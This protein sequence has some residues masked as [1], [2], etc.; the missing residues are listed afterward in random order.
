MDNLANRPCPGPSVAAFRAWVQ[1]ALA[2]LNLSAAGLG[3]DIGL[4][5][6]T[7]AQF[8][9]DPGRD[10]RMGTAHDVTCKLREIAH[11]RGVTLPKLRVTWNG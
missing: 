1:D 9:N 8:L 11:D 3:R 2:D 6:N 4:G 7:L 10:I 5:K